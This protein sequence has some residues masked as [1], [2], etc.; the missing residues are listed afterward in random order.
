MSRVTRRSFLGTA[1]AGTAGALLPGQ[2]SAGQGALE[3]DQR[4]HQEDVV[5]VGTGGAACAAAAAAVDGGASVL[6][7]ESAEAA[8]GTT[9]RSGGAFWIRNN[10]LMRA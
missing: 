10:S 1:L 4:G 9:R 2:V 6:M 7:L 3:S 8:G 5:V